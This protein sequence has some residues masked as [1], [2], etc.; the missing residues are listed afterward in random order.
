MSRRQII[1]RP[2][3]FENAVSD[4]RY[5][6]ILEIGIPKLNT[7]PLVVSDEV[8]ELCVVYQHAV[9]LLDVNT[10]LLDKL[11]REYGMA[12]RTHIYPKK[13]ELKRTIEAINQYP[14]PRNLELG[15]LYL[16]QK[17]KKTIPEV[18][19]REKHW[20]ENVRLIRETIGEE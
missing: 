14:Y 19:F 9:R 2:V 16:L 4:I 10:P 7:V 5:G 17:N 3:I 11:F 8:G 12:Q 6:I 1:G 20:E 13:G 18:L 15:N